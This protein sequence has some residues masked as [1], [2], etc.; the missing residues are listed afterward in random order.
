[1]GLH[2][3]RMVIVAGWVAVVLAGFWVTGA[4]SG[5]SLM[6]LAVALIG[7]PVVMLALWSEGPP[8]TV[9]EILYEAERKR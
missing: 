1:M 7:P 8:Q 6:M 5:F 4:D 2:N 3:S 9:G